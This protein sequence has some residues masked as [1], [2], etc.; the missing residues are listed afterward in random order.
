[1]TPVEEKALRRQL[2]SAIGRALVDADYEA[3]LLARPQVELGTRE[4]ASSY[5]TL[6]ELAQHLLRLFWPAPWRTIKHYS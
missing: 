5:T 4:V 1:V 2:D 3:E 6:P